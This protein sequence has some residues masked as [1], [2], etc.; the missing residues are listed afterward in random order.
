[1]T[2]DELEAWLRETDEELLRSLWQ[3]ADDARRQNVG[4]EVHLRG[5]VEFSNHCVRQCAYCGLRAGALGVHRYRMT[6][7]EILGCAHAAV[8][9]GY[10]TL[11]LQ[12]GEDY[13][14]TA[15]DVA[16]IVRRVKDETPLAVTLS[17]G[18]RTDEEL[19]L[20]RQAGADRYLLRFETSNPKLYRAIHPALPGRASDRIVQ[21]R[22]L[23]ELGYEVGSGVM[24]GIPG[25]T[26][27]DL[28]RDL[29]TFEELGL[30]MVGVGPYLA[31]PSTPLGQDAAALA[32]A[33]E[34]QVPNTELMTYKVVALT[35][36]VCPKANIP[37]TTALAT[38]NRAQGRELGL[39]RGANVV[40]PN[41]TPIDYRKHYQIYPGKACL[42][43]DAASCHGCL[44]HRIRSIGR[45]VGQGRGDSPSHTQRCLLK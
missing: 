37:S 6:E 45:T 19:A 35:R 40:M 31:H 39:Q 43:E 2:L 17:L 23:R 1:M 28:A 38:V 10:G 14:F 9:F 7:D 30:D 32:S 13:G 3:L 34:G 44:S 27:A 24:V 25:Q 16:G 11:V 12:S 26:Y 5:L 33:T 21:L 15:A 18:E 36:L 4:G 8:G 20:W 41:I 22:R 42:M 29:A